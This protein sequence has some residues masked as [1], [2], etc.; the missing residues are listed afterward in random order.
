MNR[1]TIIRIAIPKALYES[2]KSKVLNESKTISVASE[3]NFKTKLDGKLWTVEYHN[4]EVGDPIELKSGSETKKGTVKKVSPDGDIIIQL[5][6]AKKSAKKV[7][8]AKKKPSAGLTKKAKSAIVKKAESGKN[9]GKG[10]FDKLANK[11]AKEYGSKESGKKV[12]AAAM[13][14]NKAKAAAKKK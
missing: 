8:E 5:S 11:A 1:N 3:D 7:E 14:K 2:V 6:E 13:W 12:A 4:H 10:G 9:V